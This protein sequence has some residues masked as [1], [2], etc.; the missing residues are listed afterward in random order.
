[1]FKQN[2]ILLLISSFI[3]A[4]DI[5]S[6]IKRLERENYLLE[7][8]QK[9]NALKRNTESSSG[10]AKN[11][12]SSNR[13]KGSY[14]E[15][16]INSRQNKDMES[17][18]KTNNLEQIDSDN[19]NDLTM[20][21]TKSNTKQN[22]NSKQEL[23]RA[24]NLANNVNLAKS[25]FL[26]GVN[27]GFFPKYT[28]EGIC[29]TYSGYSYRY[30]EITDISLGLK[31]GY[32][33]FFNPYFGLR[34]YIEFDYGLGMGIGG[35]GNILER[36]YFHLSPNLD[37]LL[38]YDFYKFLNGYSLAIGSILG[39]GYGYLNYNDNIVFQKMANHN[40][41]LRYGISLAYGNG[42]RIELVGQTLPFP[43]KFPHSRPLLHNAKETMGKTTFKISYTRTF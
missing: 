32:Q 24:E 9:N 1:M 25:G 27:F 18:L 11:R 7:L 5:E 8:K 26:L 36:K 17:N 42:H 37:L 39:G 28:C 20:Q 31:L 2:L 13:N 33:K 15:N 19:Y 14:Y 41:I 23:V 6:E 16:S 4:N 3:Y 35:T 22:T 34:T 21:D 10:N 29:G 30:I 12:D 38:E 43:S 40:F